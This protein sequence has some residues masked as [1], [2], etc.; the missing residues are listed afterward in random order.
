MLGLGARGKEDFR[1]RTR[2]RGCVC[3]P[4][5][6]DL[7]WRRSGTRRESER[8]R[9]LGCGICIGCRSGSGMWSLGSLLLLARLRDLLL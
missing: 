3:G 5:G 2:L 8:C 4:S 9:L 6:R 7:G 1:R